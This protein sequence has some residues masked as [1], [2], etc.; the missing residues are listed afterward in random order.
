MYV[1]DL[2]I[3]FKEIDGIKLLNG[4]FNTADKDDVI[5]KSLNLKKKINKQTFKIILEREYFNKNKN[6]E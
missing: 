2:V 3:V 6:F 4:A 5:F 1:I